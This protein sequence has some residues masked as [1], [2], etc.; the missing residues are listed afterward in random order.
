MSGHRQAL[1]LAE[2]DALWKNMEQRSYK[3]SE[4][5]ALIP[6]QARITPD[7]AEKTDSIFSLGSY[8]LYT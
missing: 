5:Y 8:C 4:T 1:A 7:L 2:A 3:E 6:C